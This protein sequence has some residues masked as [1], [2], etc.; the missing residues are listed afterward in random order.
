[1]SIAGINVPFVQDTVINN[2]NNSVTNTN[3]FYISGTGGVIAAGISG[4]NLVTGTIGFTGIGGL[5]VSLQTGLA[6]S[7][8]SGLF[9]FSGGAGGG[10][11]TTNVSFFLDIPFS[12]NAISEA[13]VP[14]NWTFTG[15]SL[16]C[17]T[18]GSGTFP[19]SGNLYQRDTGN[20]KYNIT[21]FT[22]EAAQFFKQSGGFS[23]VITGQNRVG[24]DIT[25]NLS[26]IQG[27]TLGMFSS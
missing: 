9:V 4:K 26:G 20:T 16:G 2:V 7:G 23:T 11:S 6:A 15:Y 27:F 1:M 3:N 19:M 14:S 12:G 17:T 13:I 5:V 21:G 10:S 22:F 8:F 24:F 18:T 25:N